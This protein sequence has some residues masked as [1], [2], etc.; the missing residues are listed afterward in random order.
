MGLLGDIQK[1]AMKEK[2]PEFRIGDVVEVHVKIREGEKERIQVFSG[3]VIGRRGSGMGESFT[4]R[5]IVAGEGV[6]RVFPIHSPTV[7]DVKVTRH[8]H[9][10]RA[11]LY[12]LR[13]RKGK[14]SRVK[15]RRREKARKI[16]EIEEVKTP[17]A[18]ETPEAPEGTDAEQT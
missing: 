13:E 14:A 18:A 4:V 9:V 11:K 7:V 5:R 3:T 12:Y 16:D 2:L 15:E 1:E 8:G 6:E 17:D 10:R